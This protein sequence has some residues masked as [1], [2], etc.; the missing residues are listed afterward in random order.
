MSTIILSSILSKAGSIFGPIGQIAGSE[1]GALLGAQLDNAIFGLD[2][3]QKITHG[4]RLK[5]LQVQTSTYGKAIPIIYGTARIAG[6]II[7]SQPIKEEAI[8]TENKTGRGINI[9]YNYYAT[10]AIAICKGK[11]EKLNRIWADIKSLSFDEIDYTFY[12]GRE[13]QNP[14]PFMLSIEGEKNVPAY[15]GI[16]YIVI[17]NFPLADYSNRVPV[18]TFEVQTALKLSGFSVAENI[19]NI[20]IIPGSGEFVYDTKIQKK[21]AREKISSSQYIPYGPVQRVNHNN[22][23]KKSDAM[24]SLDQLKE[25]LPNVEWASVVVNWFASSLNIKDCKIYPAVEFQDDSAIV[26]DDWQ[27]GNITRDNAQLISKDEGG[28]PRYGGTVSDLALIRYIEEL[29]SRGYKVM[30]Y[31]MFLLDTKN[32]EWRGKLSGAPQ[33]ISDFFENQYS[34]FIGH[35]TSIAKQTK[36]E[37]FIIGSEFAQLTRVKDVEGNYPAVAELV[38]VAKQVKLQLG[39]EVNVTYAADWSEYHS[40]DGWYNM[41]ELW[42]SEFIDVV[43]IDA[44]FPLTDGEEPPFGYSAEDVA[45]GWSSGVGYDYFYDYS[46]SDPEKIK[47]NDSEYA[48]KNIEKW[49]NE[50]HVNPDGSKT[51]WQPKMKK[52]WFTEYGFPSMNGCT[53]EPNVFVDKGSIE[54]KYPRYSNGEVSFLS[55]KTAIEGTLKKWQSSEMVEKMFLW[56]WDARPFPYFPNLCDMWADCHNWQTGHWVQGKISQL[57]VSDVL[58][59][60]LQKVGLKGDQFDTSDVKGLL[61]GCVINDQQ[62]VRSIIKMLRSCYFFDVVEQNSKLKFI[63]KGRGVTTEIPIDE[64]VCNN[65]LKLI[66]LSQL[67]LNNRINIVYFNRNFGYP[68]DVKYAELPKQGSTATVEIPLI[69]E[70]GEA[71]NIAEVLLYSSWQERN[72]YNFK[73]PIKYAWLAPSNVITISDGEKKHTVRIV[74]TKFESMSIQVIGVGYD[75]SIYKLSF[76]STRSLMLKEYPP[77]HISK[78]IIE[79][80]DLPHIKGNIASFTLISEEEGWKGATLFIS[81][82]DK[83]YKPIASAN[84]QSTYGYVIEF[85]DDEIVVVLRFGQLDVINSTAL[86]LIGKE[87]IQFQDTKLID[88]NKY[89]L[90]NLIRGQESTKRYE[91]TTGEKFVLLDDSI[92]SFEVQKGKKLYL[93]A[94]TYGDS[95]D[96][97]ETKVLTV[98]N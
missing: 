41:D 49:W 17:K 32:K 83:D 79:M 97:T 77:F 94:V 85:T 38:K 90:S 34:K 42:S 40:Y 16:S 52:I 37:G 50:A 84:I 29:H 44:Y 93:K 27:V 78:T 57:N 30:L 59:D 55:Q 68:I 73:L 39:K 26:P 2:A 53:N 98:D 61:S 95:L 46:K 10:L 66:Q 13:D 91:H 4:A 75:S 31:P 67:D 54:S 48:W 74:K 96:N 92:I 88:K 12:H 63:Q 25:S 69:M 23:T 19:K 33:D 58:S 65:S 18:F 64:I 35:Y 1:L 20:N 7:W 87:V 81:Y 3:E 76:S 14:D 51:K 45:G 86:A 36:V 21:I 8:T 72:V 11:V 89:K 56:A 80:I 6:N 15:R 82:D 28:N 60:L 70:E 47:Y 71:Q 24:L 9:T 62:P 43:G 5:N 22:H